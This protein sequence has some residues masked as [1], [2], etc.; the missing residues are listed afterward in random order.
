MNPGEMSVVLDLDAHLP[1]D[2]GQRNTVK[3]KLIS[4]L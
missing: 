1:L 3:M 2:W 4:V